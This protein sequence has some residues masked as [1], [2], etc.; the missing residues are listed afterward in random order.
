MRCA[1]FETRLNEVLDER[2][3]LD[4]DPELVDHAQRCQ[5]C[6]SLA[7]SYEAIV[8][9][10]EQA[11]LPE[12]SPAL[13]ARI[14][15]ALPASAT[16]SA[17]PDVIRGSFGA[18]LP[19]LPSSD[20]KRRGAGWRRTLVGLAAAAAL[21]FAVSLRWNAA[22]PGERP[23][24]PEPGS[25]AVRSDAS[26]P[27]AKVAPAPAPPS[28]S[29]PYRALAAE[30][31]NSVSMAMRLFPGVS[32][33]AGDAAGS[34]NDAQASGWVHGVSDGLRPVTRTTTSAVHSFFELLA[35]G[36]EGSRS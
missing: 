35:G 8:T 6:R 10:L 1:E 7:S 2:L 15:S 20:G 34:S 12:A 21:L 33:M 26:P 31:S 5:P 29:D 13:T 3:W 27:G 36:D 25:I 22:G 18:H 24:G 17:R 14:V 9:G 28:A 4:S 11:K 16:E 30:T 32:G 23:A 19:S